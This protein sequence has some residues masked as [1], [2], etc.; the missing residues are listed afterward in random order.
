MAALERRRDTD[1][2]LAYAFE[3]FL[4]AS[5]PIALGIDLGAALLAPR[6][7]GV[8]KRHVRQESTERI[9]LRGTARWPGE[10]DGPLANSTGKLWIG[11]RAG[12]SDRRQTKGWN[13]K[14]R[15]ANSDSLARQQT[16][17]ARSRDAAMNL[18]PATAAI[19]R[20]VTFTVGTGLMAIPDLDAELLGLSPEEKAAW[21][22]RIMRDFDEY[23]SGTDPDAERAT[24]GYTIPSHSVNYEAE[25]TLPSSL[26]LTGG[27]PYWIGFIPDSNCG[28]ML[29]G[30]SLNSHV[31]GSSY[32]SP[33]T[34]YSGGTSGTQIA[35]MTINVQSSASP[36]GTG[37][38]ASS[39]PV[40]NY[41]AKI[42]RYEVNDRAFFNVVRN[43]D[44]TNITADG[45]T[46]LYQANMNGTVG[47]RHATFWRLMTGNESGW[48]RTNV[49]D[50]NNMLC[51]A[52]VARG[53]DTGGT[54]YEGLAH[55]TARTTTILGNSVTTTGSNRVVVNLY[56]QEDD[57]ADTP[58]TT[59]VGFTDS[60]SSHS[61]PGVVGE[62]LH[63]SYLTK[64]SAGT[65]NAEN[66]TL[67]TL[68]RWQSVTLAL[69]M[70]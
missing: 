21:T 31:L 39:T 56:G 68:E 53:V 6:G 64:A 36:G 28:I 10:I 8:V 70:A 58:D 14:A 37:I 62:S 44:S 55:S 43:V 51:A 54:W 59:A 11:Y 63:L 35:S 23:M 57:T 5:G 33:A 66:R 42:P 24:T 30:E 46:E 20:N 15:S 41:T 48:V 67:G 61:N 19:E 3:L 69:I 7:L 2:A 34:T 22:R 1:L 27:T 29:G 26:S 47:Y 18:P 45:F 49:T 9:D 12:Q 60:Y 16:L 65:V 40:E 32:A 38:I 4:E 25:L 50:S 52:T 13:A 17:I